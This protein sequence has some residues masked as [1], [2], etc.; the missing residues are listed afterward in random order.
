MKCGKGGGWEINL[1]FTIALQQNLRRC[2]LNTPKEETQKHC[3]PLIRQKKKNG[4]SASNSDDLTE[5]ISCP[6]HP[7]KTHSLLRGGCVTAARRANCLQ[8]AESE[9]HDEHQQ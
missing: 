8:K 7:W 2:S 1:K 4:G 6:S 3:E 5:S 9:L